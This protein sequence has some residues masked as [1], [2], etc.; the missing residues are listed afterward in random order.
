M[1]SIEIWTKKKKKNLNSKH[2]YCCQLCCKW[3]YE[4]Q[5]EQNALHSNKFDHDPSLLYGYVVHHTH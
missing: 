3:S 4:T 2:G 1:G 5:S